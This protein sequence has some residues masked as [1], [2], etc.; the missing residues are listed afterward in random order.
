MRSR[1]S[2]GHGMADY[3]F[4]CAMVLGFT[5]SSALLSYVLAKYSMYPTPS[6]NPNQLS[7]SL[8]N[9]LLPVPT[10]TTPTDSHPSPDLIAS[11]LLLLIP[12]PSPATEV[13]VTYATRQVNLVLV[14]AVIIGS[15]RR[16]LQGAARALRATPASR[17]RVAS[18]VLLAL[19]QLMARA[20]LSYE[21]QTAELTTRARRRGVTGH[22]STLNAHTAPHFVPACGRRRQR[23]AICDA[24]GI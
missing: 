5:A 20:L 7:Q 17:N 14:G 13:N 15:I 22:I 23:G 8:S 10:P 11:T 1:P 4:S 9:I 24:S 2:T 21:Q 19:A 18:L 3:S 6:D 12:H 16:V